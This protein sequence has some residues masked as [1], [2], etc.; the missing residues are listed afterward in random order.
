MNAFITHD[1]LNILP[2][3]S[4]EL[5]IGMDFLKKN[6]VMLNCF[7]KT[8]TCIYDTR[9]TIKVKGIL[10]KVTIR[11]IYALQMKRYV[12]KGPKVFFVYV[13]DDKDNKKNLK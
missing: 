3:G 11:E 1:D 2:L 9:N 4:Y 10:R 5:L 6:I 8:F 12:C 7:D 13:M